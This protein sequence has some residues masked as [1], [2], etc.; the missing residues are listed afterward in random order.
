MGRVVKNNL[1]EDFWKLAE[2]FKEFS[3]RDRKYIFL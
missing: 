2:E 1:K 3:Q